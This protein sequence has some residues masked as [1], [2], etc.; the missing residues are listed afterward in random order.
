MGGYNGGEIASNLATLTARDYIIE[1]FSKIDSEK[2]EDILKL[3]RSAMREA[4]SVVNQRA[5][6]QEELEQMGTTLEV[7]LIY[8]NRA[9]IGHIGDSRIYRIRKGAIRR[10]T[11]DHSYVQQLVKDGT[12]T[13]EE[14]VDHPKKNM[15]VKAIRIYF[16]YY[17]GCVS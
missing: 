16:I 8:N 12:I 4:N 2:K 10:L 13:K 1:N 11:T 7:C 3:I 5:S 9:H 14:A 17:S 6:E 15:L